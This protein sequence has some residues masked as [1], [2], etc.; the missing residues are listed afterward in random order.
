MKRKRI[1]Y[2][3]H[4]EIIDIW[5]Q[6]FNSAREQ[7]D[8][9][10][11]YA[12][13]LNGAKEHIIRL[14]EENKALRQSLLNSSSEVRNLSTTVKTLAIAYSREI[15]NPVFVSHDCVTPRTG[16]KLPMAF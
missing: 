8:Q 15:Q 2:A 16:L 1:S 5:Q 4:R 12:G 3:K 10:K 13:E 11:K 6:R 9:A 7:L 14:E